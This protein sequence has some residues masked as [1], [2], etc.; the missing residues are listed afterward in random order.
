MSEKTLSSP[1]TD[2]KSGYDHLFLSDSSSTFFGFES[3]N[4]YFV[5]ATTPFGW[6]LSAY[7]YRTTG[8][9]VSH[10]FRSNGIPCSLY[11]DDRHIGQLR[12]QW[13]L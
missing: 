6:K 4:W 5:S 12:P 11:I 8:S 13:T 1:L 7:V 3:A 2:D 10:Y 9:E